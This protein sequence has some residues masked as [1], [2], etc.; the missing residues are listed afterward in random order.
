MPNLR[1]EF[2][3][4]RFQASKESECCSYYVEH[5]PLPA[6]S[7]KRLFHNL[8]STIMKQVMWKNAR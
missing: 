1:E 4:G 8:L 2:L 3:D 7:D 6:E 5:F